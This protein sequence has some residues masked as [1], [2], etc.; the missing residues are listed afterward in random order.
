MAAQQ[1]APPPPQVDFSTTMGSFS[2]ELYP[3]YAPKT[4]KNLLELAK[5]GYYDGTVFHRIIPVR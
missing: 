3:T 5:R 2:V 1:A 4:C